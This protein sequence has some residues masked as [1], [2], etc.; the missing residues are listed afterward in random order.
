VGPASDVYG[1]GSILYYLLTGRPPFVAEE[2]PD[3]LEQVLKAEPVRPRLLNPSVPRAVEIICLKCLE[4]DPQLR[5]PSAELLAFDLECWLRHKPIRAR[6]SNAQETVAGLT[7]PY[8]LRIAALTSVLLVVAVLG[9]GDF[10]LGW[11]DR[12]REITA[13]AG[14]LLAVGVAALGLAGFL[15]QW[16]RAEQERRA[17]QQACAEAADWCR[18]AADQ[19]DTTAQYNLGVCYAEGKGVPPDPVEAHKWLHLASSQGMGKAR[20]LMSTVE[21]QMTTEQIAEAQRLVREFQPQQAP[22]PGADR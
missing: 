4:K 22:A 6:P 18:R 12:Q 9:W 11:L 2:L 13:L 7:L 10:L 8:A 21:R 5:Y 19:G 17:A 3:V 20:E 15:W 14:P 16:K 1:A